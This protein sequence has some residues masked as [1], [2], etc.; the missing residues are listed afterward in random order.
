MVASHAA[1]PIVKAGK[2][3]WNETEGELDARE[4]DRVEVH[5]T[6]HIGPI[7]AEEIRGR[8]RRVRGL[9]DRGQ[10]TTD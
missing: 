8:R 5:R 6:P 7:C 3:M 1:S 9:S 10:V 4:Q 2:M